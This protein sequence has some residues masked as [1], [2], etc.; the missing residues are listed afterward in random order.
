MNDTFVGL[1]IGAI[2]FLDEGVEETLDKVQSL[3]GVNALMVGALSWSR[4]NA[5]RAEDGFPDHGVAEPD[6]LKGGAF[7]SPDQRYY[8]GTTI[9]DFTAPDELYGGF[10]TLADVIPEARKRGIA[11]YPYYCETA[12][13]SIR[14]IWQP[15][16][17]TVLEVDASGSVG[18]RPC[19]RNP[20]YRAWW[21]GV[22]NN[23][24]SEYD[25]EGLLWGIERQGPLESLLDGDVATCFCR[26][27][28]EA[29]HQRGIDAERAAEGYRRV[30]TFLCAAASGSE[31][32][33][34]GYLITFMRLLSQYPEISQ[35]ENLWHDAH[36]S[37]YRSVYGQV[38][39]HSSELQVGMHVWQKIDTFSPWLR[40]QHDP[41]ELRGYAD[42]VK[43]VLYNVPAGFRFKGYLD[44]L[45]KTVLGDAPAE[46]WA[47]ILYQI[48]GL[49]EASYDKV[50]EAGFGAGYVR[51]ETAR[52]VAAVGPETR[53]YPGLGVGV[54]PGAR[55]VSPKD[56]ETMVEAAFAG[57]G[58]GVV[59][60]RNYSELML[61]NLEAVG[62]TLRNLGRI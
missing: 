23:W 32:P 21:S 38:K 37:M 3:G 29:G 9:K 59:I 6:E 39:Y 12:G 27:C 4:G 25:L 8:T 19:Q 16:F 36:V 17:A 48:L 56:V 26:Y 54:E 28:R 11:V 58:S 2:S 44:R 10:D 57:G 41:G 42:W 13:S 51:G 45:C 31:R 22:I 14:P 55:N 35:W 18:T 52:Y 40:A 53:V 24:F 1:Q 47:P 20:D 34:D 60:S 46:E 49:D 30:S 15:G 7:F 62:T 33:R 43:P 5:G 61:E 50:P